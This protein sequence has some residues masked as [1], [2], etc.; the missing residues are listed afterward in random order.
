[1]YAIPLALLIG[2]TTGVVVQ[3][4]MVNRTMGFQLGNLISRRLRLPTRFDY[5]TSVLLT[6]V[7]YG[8]PMMHSLDVF[9]LGRTGTSDALGQYSA[10]Y[11]LGFVFADAYTL[12]GM[13]AL[14]HFADHRRRTGLSARR[15]IALLV[16]GAGIVAATVSVLAQPL[17]H[18]VFGASYADSVP[19]LQGFAFVTVVYMA[20]VMLANFAV[21]RHRQRTVFAAYSVGVT[22]SIVLKLVLRPSGAWDVLATT[23]AAEVLLLAVLLASLWRERVHESPKW[24]NQPDAH[25]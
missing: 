19:L 9:W 4:V 18:A 13:T 14:S 11:R 2:N 20:V 24:E 22:I 1:V 25:H 5:T 17:V 6:F 7:S 21:A 12:I 16:F 23:I 3:Y 15:V 8:Y 10:A